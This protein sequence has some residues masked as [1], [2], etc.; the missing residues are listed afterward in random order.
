MSKIIDSMDNEHIKA[1]I[2]RHITAPRRSE[3]DMA[4]PADVAGCCKANRKSPSPTCR[5]TWTG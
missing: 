1:F 5:C 2:E 4:K 3:R